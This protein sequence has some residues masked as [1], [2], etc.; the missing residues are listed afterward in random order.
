MNYTTTLNAAFA[1][2]MAHTAD[3]KTSVTSVQELHAQVKASQA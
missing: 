1:T 3:A 2:C